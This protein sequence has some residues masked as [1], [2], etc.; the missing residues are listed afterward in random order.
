MLWALLKSGLPA[1]EKRVFS[2]LAIPAA[3]TLSID[4]LQD[5][6]DHTVVDQEMNPFRFFATNF[7]RKSDHIVFATDIAT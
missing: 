7:A 6:R 2:S 1:F 4:L 5:F 3:I